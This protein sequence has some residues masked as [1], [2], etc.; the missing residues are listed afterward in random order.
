[1]APFWLQALVLAV[2][3]VHCLF[4]G[5]DG[6]APDGMTPDEAR[7]RLLSLGPNM[8]AYLDSDSW[9][10][11]PEHLKLPMVRELARTAAG[12][13][14]CNFVG[15]GADSGVACRSPF[16]CYADS[17]EDELSP[18]GQYYLKV[19]IEMDILHD[20]ET[21]PFS[22]SE[23]LERDN[24]EWEAYVHVLSSAYD[25]TMELIKAQ[26]E[27][28]EHIEEID[29]GHKLATALDERRYVLLSAISAVQE[30][31]ERVF[32]ILC[33]QAPKCCRGL[34]FLRTSI[35]DRLVNLTD[36]SDLTT[37]TTMAKHFVDSDS[38]NHDIM[39]EALQGVREVVCELDSQACKLVA[40]KPVA[41]RCNLFQD[42]MLHAKPEDIK[43][44]EL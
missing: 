29:E 20:G 31:F 27:V 10:T 6:A 14:E 25:C 42:G 38:A 34:D 21:L 9:R 24:D 43:K 16:Q 35:N 23:F 2:V 4:S 22:L 19:G 33:A 36:A 12:V 28:E 17:L 18:T 13:R 30:K 5:A 1:M 39:E 44:D 7:E 26:K 37:R 41:R 40:P 32:R 15:Y 3:S 11:A 8:Q